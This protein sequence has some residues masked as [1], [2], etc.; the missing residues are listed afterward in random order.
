MSLPSGDQ[1]SCSIPPKGSVGSSY[2]SFP[3]RSMLL[4]ST[5]DSALPQDAAKWRWS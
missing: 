5:V 3:S 2:G 4:W 1:S